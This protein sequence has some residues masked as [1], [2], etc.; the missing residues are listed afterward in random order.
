MLRKRNNKRMSNLGRVA[1]V[2]LGFWGEDFAGLGESAEKLG[3]ERTISIDPHLA[4][5]LSVAGECVDPLGR[6]GP[7]FFRQICEPLRIGLSFTLRREF[8]GIFHQT[9]AFE[10][11][12]EQIGLVRVEFRVPLVLPGLPE[13]A[14]SLDGEFMRAV[15]GEGARAAPVILVPRVDAF[16]RDFVPLFGSGFA[17]LEDGGEDVVAVFEDVG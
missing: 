14:P 9:C 13:V 15:F 4:R 1:S 10:G 5:E 12:A 7:H 2:A 8:G 3:A 11:L 17:P 6:R 16:H